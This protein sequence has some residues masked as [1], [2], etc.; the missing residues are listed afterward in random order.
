MPPYTNRCFLVRPLRPRDRR[1]CLRAHLRTGPNGPV[2][3]FRRLPNGIRLTA[4]RRQTGRPNRADRAPDTARQTIANR[5]QAPGPVPDRWGGRQRAPARQ[6]NPIRP[7]LV[8]PPSRDRCACLRLAPAFSCAP[9]VSP[10]APV[11][12][13][14]ARH[15]RQTRGRQGPMPR[16]LR[17]SRRFDPALASG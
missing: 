7:R 17:D 6:T 16:P 11:V 2:T 4:S 15:P 1:Q 10:P 5:A 8:P 14:C 12:A 3:F 13:P 9:C